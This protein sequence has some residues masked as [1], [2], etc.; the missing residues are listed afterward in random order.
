MALRMMAGRNKKTI[1]WVKT[2]L[3]KAV[4]KSGEKFTQST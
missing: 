3:Q 2:A 4:A 1:F